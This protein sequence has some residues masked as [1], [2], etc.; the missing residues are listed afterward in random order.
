MYLS[1]STGDKCVCLRGSACILKNIVLH[2]FD[3]TFVVV[4]KFAIK[5]DFC[6]YPFDRKVVTTSITFQGFHT[7][8]CIFLF[9]N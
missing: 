9:C 7:I 2:S 5:E 8:Y 3:S 6:S 1:L 4:S